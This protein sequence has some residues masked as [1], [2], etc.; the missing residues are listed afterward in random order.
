MMKKLLFALVVAIFGFGFLQAQAEI[1]VQ[2]NTLDI[3]SG[4]ATPIT[5]DG[6]DFGQVNVNSSSAEQIFVIQNTGDAPLEITTQ[7]TTNP[8]F[9][10]TTTP[11]STVAPGSSTNIGVTFVA[12]ATAGVTTAQL[13]I[14]NSDSDEDPYFFSITGEAIL[15]PNP[16][17]D[18][19]GN[20]ISIIG[21]GTNTPNTSDGTDFGSVSS[22]NSSDEQIFVIQNQ[23]GQPLSL[24]SIITTN[25]EFAITTS[26]TIPS[27]IP[28]GGSANLGITFNAGTAGVRTATLFISNGDGDENPYQ[29]N[30]RAIS[31]LPP[32]E[33]NVTG[34][35]ITIIGNA[36]NT[37][38]ASDGTDFGQVN[39]S[40][41]SNE[42]L[43]VIQN[44]GTSPLS[45]NPSFT[46]N[47]AFTIS[48]P[49]SSSI[50][51]GGT[52][53]I[54]ITFNAPATAGVVNAVLLIN[55]DDPDENPYQINLTA[56]AV[57]SSNPEINVTG[58]G[59]SIVGNAT[60]TPNAS[61]GTDFGDV[62]ISTSSS[63]QLFV[64]QN[65]GSSALNVNPSFTTNP[66][67]TIT[68]VAVSPVPAGGTTTIGVTFNAPATTGVV[69]A[70]L[71]IN[72]NDGDENPYQINL[73]AEAINVVG[74]E[75]DMLDN[76]NA[77]LASGGSV[78]FGS[79]DVS[80]GSETFTF[81]IQNTGTSDL[82]LDGAS[83]FV[84]IS[85]ANAADFTLGTIPSSTIGASSSTTFTITFNPSAIG[86]R[87]ASV[88]IANNDSNENPY[89]F[90]LTGEG[91]DTN[92][93]SP[94]LITQYYENG[95]NDYIEIKN[96]SS[97]T[98]SSVTQ[99][100]Y[101]CLYD[102]DLVLSSISNTA[103]DQSIQ[104]PTLSPGQVVVYR[105]P[106]ASGAGTP[107]SAA[108][109]SGRDV[110]MISSTNDAGCY[111]ARIDIIGVIG[112]S[113]GTDW[114]SNKSLI[115]GC[116]TNESPSQT[117]GYNA[118]A[119][120]SVTDYIT[121]TTA[122]VD[123]A[124]ANT[125]LF[126]GTQTVGST[127]YTSSWSN[128]IPDKTKN[129]I[130]NGTYN[131]SV[132]SFETC[133][134]TINASGNVNFGGG[135]SNFV[136]VNNDLFINGGFTLGDNA[137]LITVDPTATITG[138]ITKLESSTTLNTSDDFTYW[139]SPV[140]GAS[141]SVF[142]STGAPANR[143]F[144]W[145]KPLTNGAGDYG[146]WV[147]KSGGLEQARGY[148]SEAPSGSTQ[149]NI[150]FTGSPH[151]GEVGIFVNVDTAI[152][153]GGGGFNLIGNPYPSA[154]SADAFLTHGPNSEIQGGALNGSIWLWTH[155]TAYQDN[156]GEL[157][158]YNVND[159]ATYNGSGGVA[160]CGSCPVP[161]GILG[162]SQGFFV[163]AKSSG[164]VFFTNEMRVDGQNTQFFRGI[165]KKKS[166]TV[167]DRLWLNVTSKKGGAFNQILVGFF[168]NATDGEDSFYDAQKFSAGNYINFY[169]TIGE[170]KY[171]IQGLSSFSSDKRV[172]IG[173]DP[174]IKETFAI[175]LHNVEGALNNEDI[176]LVDNYLNVVHDLKASDYEFE[177]TETGSFPDRFTLQFN[178]SVLGVNDE[179]MEN[180]FIVS[181][182]N[183][184]L[185]IRSKE[186]IENIKVYDM[187]GRLLVNSNPKQTDFI[188]NTENIAKGTVL[189]L[190]ATLQNGVEVSKK[191]IKY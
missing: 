164:S 59:I 82:T 152:P 119:T 106:S 181:N 124:A 130:I 56:E 142:T 79:V 47:P 7:A 72:N 2:G 27:S 55:N 150:T 13:F 141:T 41:S 26:P 125:N 17:I 8:I 109:F 62:T 156:P 116:G 184:E 58:N 190:N 14:F 126:L 104:L 22:G 110:I 32:P 84:V 102:S 151:N 146:G 71:I 31:V 165:D 154:V 158:D 57:I 77:A 16:E 157:E 37:P 128:G 101:L 111:N 173:F 25:P 53:T 64:I 175:S 148:I 123:A 189:V 114:G 81:T 131:S 100:Y 145:R 93:G 105:N 99:P 186:A 96:I 40:T 33:I 5:A 87:N 133:D 86:T 67:F 11:S 4:D 6:T 10:I 73:R 49:A 52:T 144:E 159:Y 178:K 9:Q 28:A 103:P 34:N 21:N 163:N 129:A 138:S 168:D 70:V 54:G 43:F 185:R 46:T 44:T 136:K 61:D 120:P 75:M 36:T 115:K 68:T 66:A 20:G 45:V 108:V 50:S 140:Q 63:E 137:A 143:I 51:P 35:G 83:P 174:Y 1:N 88:S 65:T 166:N 117:F 191:A 95:N 24:S 18:V 172:S 160:A 74:P 90:T 91:T 171:A 42:Q 147:A 92:T 69:N 134:L 60:N 80:S 15:N 169:S 12:P 161:N 135:T 113:S 132:G 155:T 3:A 39:I 182:E 121:L 179:L 23:G 122:E 29:I 48:T 76:A 139:S 98:I 107:T 170:S 78:D 153:N 162:S 167:K 187:L 118:A 183:S 149:H 127:T 85:G 176:Y 177:I 30:L 97:S 112:S 188:L 89:T 38:N 180:S 19:T 94:L